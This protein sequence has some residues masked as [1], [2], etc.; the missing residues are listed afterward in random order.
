M[1]TR[2]QVDCEL[3]LSQGLTFWGGEKRERGQSEF[4]DQIRVPTDIWKL[5]PRS[6]FAKDNCFLY[7]HI[8][9][10]LHDG[11]ARIIFSQTC[12]LMPHRL[13]VIYGVYKI[14]GPYIMNILSTSQT[15][16]FGWDIIC[17]LHLTLTHEL[18]GS[19]GG[20]RMSSLRL[21]P[22]TTCRPWRCK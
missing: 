14:D 11:D 19:Q 16:T 4:G 20:Q 1:K 17:L 12:I 3:R 9:S 8:M 5:C 21:C 6:C 2:A 7:H 10:F 18:D 22:G 15:L 13:V